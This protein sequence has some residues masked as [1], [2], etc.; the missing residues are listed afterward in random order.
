MIINLGPAGSTGKGT[1][2]GIR[3]VKRLGLQA[4]EVEFV[5][6]VKMSNGLAKECGAEAKRLGI[7]L[8][9]HA[10]YYINLASEDPK[11]QKESVQRILDSCE[12]GHY[13]GAREIVFHPAYFGKGNKEKIFQIT[14][15]HIL[16]MQETIRKK[17]WDVRLSPETTGKHSALGSLEE[18]I[19]LAKETKCSF[20]IDFAHLYAR[21]YGKID[22]GEVLDKV[23]KDLKPKHIQ[24]HFSNISYTSKGER[25][26]E[27]MDHHPP[28][29]PLAKEI[30]K[31]KIDFTII[32]ESPVT[33][34]DSL[35][36]KSIFEKL[37]YVFA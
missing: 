18:T 10:P 16:D 4:M 2:E 6:G 24:C 17:G 26:H 9:V 1:L 8:S 13:L 34:K 36:M 7:E 19:R 15:G 20:N 21:N 37:G 11:K 31:R 27:V 25:N 22:Y 30:L 32:S 29:E 14:K 5:R 28:F 35:R 23:E 12:R 33:W 3:D